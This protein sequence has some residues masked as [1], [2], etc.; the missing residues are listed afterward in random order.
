MKGRTMK[1]RTMSEYTPDRWVVLEI[2]QPDH[3]PIRKLFAGWYGGSWKINS[4]ITNIRIDASGHY[5]FDGYSGSTYY[6]HANN[7]KMSGLMHGV[8]GSWLKQADTR[9]DTKIRVLTLD[10]IVKT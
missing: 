4:G 9:G 10:E 2:K 8:L 6:C 3:E 5:E 1:G 7:Y